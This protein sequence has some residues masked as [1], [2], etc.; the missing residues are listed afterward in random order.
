MNGSGT[1]QTIVASADNAPGLQEAI[2]YNQFHHPPDKK[3]YYKPEATKDF[4]DHQF[5][6]VPQR[7]AEKVHELMKGMRKKDGGA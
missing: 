6:V 1:T 2:C 3:P 7:T 4:L 5:N